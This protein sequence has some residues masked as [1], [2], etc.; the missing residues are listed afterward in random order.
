M[1]NVK[2]RCVVCGLDAGKT[3]TGCKT[4]NNRKMRKPDYD[5][6]KDELINQ[7][8]FYVEELR[9]EN[10]VEGA[11]LVKQFLNRIGNV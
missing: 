5:I 9:K 4:H 7:L 10:L 1:E 8:W 6:T 3:T 11:S 2:R